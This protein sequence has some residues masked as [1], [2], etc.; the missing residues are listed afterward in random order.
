[1]RCI[2]AGKTNNMANRQCCLSA[3]GQKD[4]QREIEWYMRK[5]MKEEGRLQRE[6]VEEETSYT[7]DSLQD[8]VPG[9]VN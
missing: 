4:R 7:C 1:M 6:T 2:P 8:R 3:G 5:E 9:E